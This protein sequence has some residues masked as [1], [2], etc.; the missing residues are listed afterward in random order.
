MPNRKP[1][2]LF[3]NSRFSCGNASQTVAKRLLTLVVIA[4]VSVF[5]SA[6]V[7][8]D[9]PVRPNIVW[10]MSEDN[11]K[12][13]LEHFDPNGVATPAIESMAAHGITF[14][15]AFSNAPVCSVARTT[16]ITGCYG[17]RIGT[18][19][20]RRIQK[21]PMPEGL[22]M[23]PVYLKEAGYYTTNNSKEDYN[24]DPRKTPWDDSS[25]KASW[26]NRPTAD[27]PFFHVQ[28]FTDSHE[29]RLHFG[30][31]QLSK[32]TDFPTDEVHLP[33]YFPDTPLFRY[34]AAYYRDRM[35]IIDDN[36]KSIL[37][38]L[39]SQNQLENTFVFYFGDHGGV[40][41]RSKGYLFES[42]LHVPLVVRVP[43]QYRD[44]VDRPVGTRT[45][46]FVS[47]IDFGPTV[48]NLAGV[49][50]PEAMDGRAFMGPGL[51]ADAVDQ[52]DT[53]FSYAD[54]MDE[55]YDFV[56]A[57]RVG[58]W[59]Y[60]RYF[61]SQYPNS[62]LN[63]YRYKSLAYQQWRQMHQDGEL[64]A[65]QS[66]FF[67]PR[68]VEALFDL[69]KDPEETENLAG[70]PEQGNR[71]MEMRQTLMTHLKETND[72]SFY[73]EAMFLRLGIAN[74]V[75]FG[76]SHH[77]EISNY[78]DTANIALEP[79]GS[80]TSP[81]LASL[82]SGDP[83]VRYWGLVA[84]S[85]ASSASTKV[86]ELLAD[87]ETI[88][89]LARRRTLDDTPLVAARAAELL[90]ILGL[91]DPRETFYRV[92][93]QVTSEAE[94]LQIV[95]MAA[96]LHAD[97]KPSYPFEKEKVKIGW[98]IPPKSDLQLRLDYFGTASP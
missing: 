11:S 74:P 92:L 95:N 44:V 3:L 15:R 73:T 65:K 94:A 19:Y 23:F 85:S 33:A 47:F 60:I 56:R 21:A 67:Q 53:A 36:V 26:T 76:Q 97:A 91:E 57:V 52:R 10:I 63:A 88:V 34:T 4:A 78:V 13:Y 16:L 17:P 27:T 61:E 66:A 2:F 28:T 82:N 35:R 29:S 25:R 62:L 6:G 71:L 39:K 14:D 86:R 22:E 49:N 30:D 51:T 7:A 1:V 69:S 96:Y 77:D 68:P 8:A 24:A 45:K 79:A 46:A 5:H 98:K 43:D 37:A 31:A 41:P 18:Q 59:K 72:L 55:K 64:S 58:D 75:A 38:E 20:H 84:A 12:H 9:D 93:K 87:D 42:G 70:S 80:I 50:V 89:K 54:R 90:A 83:I 48:L 32:P 81:L 40:L